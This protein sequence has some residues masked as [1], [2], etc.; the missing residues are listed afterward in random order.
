MLEIADYASK[1][2]TLIEP[3]LKHRHKSFITSLNYRMVQFDFSKCNTVKCNTSISASYV[4]HIGFSNEI[5]PKSMIQWKT[6]K[7]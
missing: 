4:V 3:K 6:A 1:S 7:F 5:S 2:S